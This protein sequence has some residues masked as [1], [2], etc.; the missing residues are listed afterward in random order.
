MND[1]HNDNKRREEGQWHV[2]RAKKQ[3]INLY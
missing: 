1:I 2:K 3:K